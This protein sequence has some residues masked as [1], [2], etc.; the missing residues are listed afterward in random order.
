MSLNRAFLKYKSSNTLW[1]QILECIQPVIYNYVYNCMVLFSTFLNFIHFNFF[2]FIT[3][4]EL[5]K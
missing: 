3:L 1:I 4:F 5:P 2:T